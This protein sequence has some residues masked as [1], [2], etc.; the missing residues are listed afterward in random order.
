MKKGKKEE[1]KERRKTKEKRKKRKQKKGTR[2]KRKKHLPAAS[3]VDSPPKAE[4]CGAAL[5]SSNILS[6]PWSPV[7]GELK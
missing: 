6:S 5:R 2:K 4:P 3:Q 1:K 7:V